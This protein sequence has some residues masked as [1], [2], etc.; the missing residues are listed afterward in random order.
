MTAPLAVVCHDAVVL[1]G[2][3]GER[4]GGVSKPDVEI[5]GRRLLDHA[6]DAAAGARRVVVAGPAGLGRP[7]TPTVL[8]DP[9]L[10]G[11]VAGIQAGLAHLDAAAGGGDEAVVLVLAC[12]VPLATV[13]V[14]R[15][16]IALDAAPE[17]DG[18]VLSDPDGRLRPL[19]AVYRRAPLRAALTAVSRDGSAHG[20][21]VERLVAELTLT[22]V[23]DPEGLVRDADTWEDVA[24]LEE[25]LATTA[26]GAGGTAAGGTAAGDPG[27]GS[28]AIDAWL[29]ALAAEL[30]V[31]LAELDLPAVLD[32][33]HEVTDAVG[34]PAV[35]ATTLLL[36][37]ALARRGDDPPDRILARVAALARDRRP[38]R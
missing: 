18:A 20:V 8:E 9:P 16:L 37:W 14:P 13:V 31:D 32:L 33:A 29:V 1:A 22:P 17:A 25:R 35:P 10:G 7:G 27:T 24:R 36:G 4:L 26:A 11:P 28:A 3:R 2:G 38:A 30:E 34:R 6:L 21:P 12:D 15:L 5:A 23:P 19:V